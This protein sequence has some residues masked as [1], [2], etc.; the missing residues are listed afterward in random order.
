MAHDIRVMGHGMLSSK[1][2]QAISIDYPR[3]MRRIN[4][5]TDSRIPLITISHIRSHDKQIKKER[6]EEQ[7]IYHIL[8]Q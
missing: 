3:N 7:E 4:G 1:A 2:I 6:E 8:E 5:L